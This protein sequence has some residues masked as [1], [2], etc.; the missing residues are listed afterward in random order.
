LVF[1]TRFSVDVRYPGFRAKKR[2]AEAAHRWADQ[3][4]VAA[5]TILCLPLHPPRRKR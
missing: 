2:Q 3:V 4:R 5:R 1:L